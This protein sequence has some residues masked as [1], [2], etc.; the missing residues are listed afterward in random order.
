[1]VIPPVTSTY[2]NC[3]QKR[4]LGKIG[5]AGRNRYFQSDMTEWYPH[6]ATPAEPASDLYS[7]PAADL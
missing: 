1:M 4:F 7:N 3:F 5:A 6:R 2:R